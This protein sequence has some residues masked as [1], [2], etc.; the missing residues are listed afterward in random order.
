MTNLNSLM[1]RA[2]EN[3]GEASDTTIAN[4][5]ARARRARRARFGTGGVGGAAVVTLALGFPLI[6]GGAPASA[7]EL[8]D[9]VGSQPKGFTL[10][11]VPEGWHL[12]VADDSSLILSPQSDP[13]VHDPAS[14]VIAWEGRIAITLV[15]EESLPALASRALRVG[16]DTAQAY[17]MLDASD[18]P[19]DVMSVFVPQG[20]G[21]YLS[22][23]LPAELRWT[24]TEASQFIDGIDVDDHAVITAG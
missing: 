22:V 20:E 1:T 18:T 16:N 4:D 7:V 6:A 23:Q 11:E 24:D 2:T 8:V 14:G 10:E 5:L 15:A 12:Y 17:N 13:L 9:Y 21:T 19:S 3:I